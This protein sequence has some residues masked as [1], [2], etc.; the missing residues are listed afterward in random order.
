[1]KIKK[2]ILG[3]A[4]AIIFIL[5][6]AYAIEAFYPTPKYK[7][8]C[9]EYKTQEIINNKEQCEAIGGQWS[10]YQETPRPI[11]GEQI[12]EGYCD[13]EFTCRQELESAQEVYNRNVFFISVILGLITVIIAALLKLESVSSGL[14]GGGVI[15]IIYGTIRYWGEMSDVLRTIMLGI[16]LAILIWLGYKKIEPAMKK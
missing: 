16:V 8:Y 13:R 2:L 5:F 3:I 15:L 1:M 12:Q 11:Q 6:V 14:L 10:Q 9:G 4:I 7:D